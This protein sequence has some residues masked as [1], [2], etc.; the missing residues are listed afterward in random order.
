MLSPGEPLA[1]PSDAPLANPLSDDR[2]SIEQA[3]AALKSLESVD[4]VFYAMK[5]NPH[6][7]ILQLV[8]DGGLNIECV[9]PGEIARVTFS[10]SRRDASRSGDGFIFA[11]A[12]S[13]SPRGTLGS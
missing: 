5:A 12:C 9:S 13:A 2:D 10:G 7:E 6:R 8:H 3:V 11:V 4:A 1:P